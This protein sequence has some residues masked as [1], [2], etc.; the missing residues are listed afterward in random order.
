[1]CDCCTRLNPM[2]SANIFIFQCSCSIS[3]KHLEE[4][5][6]LGE[7]TGF[8][9]S[10][11][12]TRLPYIYFFC[13]EEEKSVPAESPR[14][15]GF[16][17]CIVWKLQANEGPPRPLSTADWKYQATGHCRGTLCAVWSFAMFIHLLTKCFALKN[18]CQNTVSLEGLVK[19]ISCTWEP[20]RTMSG[21]KKKKA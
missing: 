20:R 18:S 21:T 11:N 3:S 15:V 17:D 19:M 9:S 13:Q 16:Q 7:A 10:R 8:F 5:R 14:Q 12:E 1:M 2:R 4:V 6:C